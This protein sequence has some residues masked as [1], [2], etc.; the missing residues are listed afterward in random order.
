MSNK[1]IVILDG[2]G[3]GD[4]YLA[5]PFSVLTDILVA[6]PVNKKCYHLKEIKLAHCDGC[7]GC[8]IKT[9]G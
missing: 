3:N 2:T 4:D 8:W 1:K 6:Q 5:Y 9:P 7:F